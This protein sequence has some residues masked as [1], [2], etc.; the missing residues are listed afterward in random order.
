MRPV[1]RCLMSDKPIQPT[2][3]EPSEIV[4][5][6]MRA[7]AFGK[8]DRPWQPGT[9]W[10]EAA[11]GNAMAALAAAG[12]RIA[13]IEIPAAIAALGQ[14]CI[15]DEKQASL[16]EVIEYEFDVSPGRAAR[17]IALL[18]ERGYKIVPREPTEAM[19]GVGDQYAEHE[20]AV[21]TWRAMWDAAE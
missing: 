14:P 15:G 21:V 18:V 13:P 17:M 5:A 20:D 2:K 6:A 1:D 12:Y 3:Q 9:T 8:P 10:I 11:V 7:T 16:V 19:L 4:L